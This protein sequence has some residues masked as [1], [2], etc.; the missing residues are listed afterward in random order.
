MSC[1]K[2]RSLWKILVG[3]TIQ[4]MRVTTLMALDIISWNNFLNNEFKQWTQFNYPVYISWKT[5]PEEPNSK[6]LMVSHSRISSLHLPNLHSC[7]HYRIY[8]F[9]SSLLHEGYNNRS[10]VHLGSDMFNPHRCSNSSVPQK[11][12]LDFMKGDHQLWILIRIA[13]NCCKSLHFPNSIV[14]G[15]MIQDAEK[16]RFTT[17]WALLCRKILYTLNEHSH[18]KPLELISFSYIFVTKL[19]CMYKITVMSLLVWFNQEKK[20]L[21]DCQMKSTGAIYPLM[22]YHTNNNT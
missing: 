5:W 18:V 20:F 7:R 6:W 21:L 3:I 11:G 22:Y 1:A 16:R 19:Q 12:P 17:Q 13:N 14:D 15:K 9:S 2:I 8:L 4:I 10:T